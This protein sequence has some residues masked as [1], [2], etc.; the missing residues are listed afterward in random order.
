[1]LFVTPSDFSTLW[2]KTMHFEICPCPSHLV[3]AG[4]VDDVDTRNMIVSKT[5]NDRFV[6]TVRWT[7]LI[8]HIEEQDEISY[9]DSVYVAQHVTNRLYSTFFCFDFHLA[10]KRGRFFSGMQNIF[11]RRHIIIQQNLW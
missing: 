10:D 7:A 8:D 4:K 11:C 3:I 9:F 5:I 2:R 1:M 6:D